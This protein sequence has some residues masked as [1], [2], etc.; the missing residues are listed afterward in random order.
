[1]G[2]KN[3]FTYFINSFNVIAYQSNSDFTLLLLS[4]VT[5][6][7][8]RHYDKID[9]LKPAYIDEQSGY[10]YYETEQVSQLLLIQRLKRYGFSLAEIQQLLFTK[11]KCLLAAKLSAQKNIFLV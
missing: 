5:I 9:L 1:M 11:D 7:T 6:K 10:R 3:C 8:L 4:Q 2:N